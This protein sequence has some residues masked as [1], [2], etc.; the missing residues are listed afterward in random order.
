MGGVSLN[1][2]SAQC[3]S[4]RQRQ[5]RIEIK[6]SHPAGNRTLAAGLEGRDSTD[7]ATVKEKI[8]R[9][10]RIVQHEPN[11]VDNTTQKFLAITF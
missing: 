11:L 10:L 3:Q 1:V 9:D 7:H 8:E 2:W 4:H 5:H 6:I